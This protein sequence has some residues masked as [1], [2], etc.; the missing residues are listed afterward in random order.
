MTINMRI[1]R[2]FIFKGLLRYLTDSRSSDS[3]ESQ[4]AR[5]IKRMSFYSNCDI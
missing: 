4:K 2:D 1:E 3:I 5:L